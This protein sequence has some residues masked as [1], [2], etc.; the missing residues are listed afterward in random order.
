[1]TFDALECGAVDDEGARTPSEKDHSV[2]KSLSKAGML[3]SN[4]EQK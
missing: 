4:L 1:M 2:N 3:K